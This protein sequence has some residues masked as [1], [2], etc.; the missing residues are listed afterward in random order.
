MDKALEKKVA[1]FYIKHGRDRAFD[2]L[3]SRGLSVS[4]VEKL[5]AGTYPHQPKGLQLVALMDALDHK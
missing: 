1:A 4:I 3:R 2:I 5:L